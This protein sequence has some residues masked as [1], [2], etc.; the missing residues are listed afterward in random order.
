MDRLLSPAVWTPDWEGWNPHNSHFPPHVFTSRGFIHMKAGC[1]DH[2]QREGKADRGWPSGQGAACSPWR[3]AYAGVADPTWWTLA[4]CL[5]GQSTSHFWPSRAA[6]YRWTFLAIQRLESLGLEWSLW[7]RAFN[8]HTDLK[9][10]R[11]RG[12]IR[13]LSYMLPKKDFESIYF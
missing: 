9:Q 6:L 7:I 2:L 1:K 12:Q 4:T 5:R 3:R 13:F 11:P 8:K 10:W